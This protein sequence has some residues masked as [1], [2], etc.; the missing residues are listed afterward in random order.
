MDKTGLRKKA[1]D[2]INKVQWIPYWGKDRIYGMIENRPDW[3]VSRQR[4]WG[5][6]ITVFYCKNVRH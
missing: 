4:S 3:C 1:L 5:V 2:A 6:P